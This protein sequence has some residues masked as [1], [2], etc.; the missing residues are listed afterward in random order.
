M[1]E[2]D[3][4]FS[5]LLQRFLSEHQVPYSL[6]LYGPEGRYL[7]AAPEKVP[8]LADALLRAVGKGRD[9]E[10]FV[11]LADLL[12]LDDCLDPL[13]RRCA[14]RWAGIIRSCSSVP[15]RRAWLCRPPRD[16]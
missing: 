1:L 3:D 12:E 6:P 4:A 8:V 13:L 14:W 16:R 2:D 10:L 15:G 9:N 7:F 11:L 5:L